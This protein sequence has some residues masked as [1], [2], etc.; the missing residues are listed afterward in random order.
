MVSEVTVDVDI[1]KFLRAIYFG[2]YTNIY[3]AAANRAYL[4]MNRTLRFHNVQDEMRKELRNQVSEILEEEIKKV[5]RVYIKDQ[6]T[7]DLWHFEICKKI[8]MNYVDKDIEF[9]IGQSQKWI[10]MT[11]KYLYML[12]DQELFDLF[13]YLHIPLDNYVFNVAHKEFGLSIPKVPWS[14][15]DSY[16]GQYLQYQKNLRSRI[17]NKEPLRWEFENWLKEAR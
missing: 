6:D 17:E 8:Q 10:N 1:L 9:T 11:F 4:D 15:W 12:G 13:K 14:R 5:K 3:K 16:E 2:T 7:F